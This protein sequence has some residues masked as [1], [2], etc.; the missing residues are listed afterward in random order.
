MK[1]LLQLFIALILILSVTIPK[2]SLAASDDLIVTGE[3]L[4]LREG[5]GLSYPI[6]TKFKNGIHYRLLKK[7]ATGFM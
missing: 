3:I 5:P 4:N 6:L 7:L 1:K 2:L